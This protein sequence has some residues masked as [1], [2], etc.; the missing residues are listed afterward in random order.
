M[1][2]TI[3]IK[4]KVGLRPS[5]MV[6]DLDIFCFKDYYPFNNTAS[7]IQ[8]QKIIVKDFCPIKAKIMNPKSA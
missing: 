3:N 7:K 5:I 4:A 6:Q 2:K 1:Q 8:T